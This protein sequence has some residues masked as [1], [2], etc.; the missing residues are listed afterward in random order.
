MPRE[1]QPWIETLLAELSDGQWHSES[2]VVAKMCKKVPPG[3]AVRTSDNDQQRASGGRPR[4]RMRTVAEREATGQRAVARDGL[5]SWV[6]V[7]S[8][9]RRGEGRDREV[10]LTPKSAN[11]T[12]WTVKQLAD[13]LERS[14]TTVNAWLRSVDGVT[15]VAGFLPAE[16]VGKVPVVRNNYA[17]HW[18]IPAAAVIAWER[19]S[20]TRRGVGPAPVTDHA[21]ADA[22]AAVFGLDAETA[23]VRVKQVREHLA[24]GDATAREPLSTQ[25]ASP[26]PESTPRTVW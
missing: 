25:D 16:L 4:V 24:T 10:R 14:A 7:G 21:L 3:V 11:E 2:V 9:Q 26:D 13:H 17:G 20:R 15:N 6:H 18:R 5:R 1:R 23:A 19:Y 22:I 8:I 12:D